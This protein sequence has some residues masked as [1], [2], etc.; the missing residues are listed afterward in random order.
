MSVISQAERSLRQRGTPDGR[1]FR[2]HRPVS[3]VQAVCMLLCRVVQPQL[4]LA[5]SGA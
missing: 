3:A 5:M 2:E 4:T 1:R